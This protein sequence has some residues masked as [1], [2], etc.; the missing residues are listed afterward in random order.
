M[1]HP[2]PKSDDLLRF[3]SFDTPYWEIRRRETAF[4]RGDFLTAM[5]VLSLTLAT[6]EPNI[7][8]RIQTSSFGRF[9][10]QTSPIPAAR[11]QAQKPQAPAARGLSIDWKKTPKVGDTIAGYRVTSG[12]GQRKKPCPRCS[13]FHPAIDLGTPIGTPLYA[14][15]ETSVKC[16]RDA[17]G[18]GLVAEYALPGQKIVQLLHLKS[19]KNGKA[20]GG[21]QIAQSGNSGIGTGAHLDLRLKPRSIVPPTELIERTLRPNPTSHP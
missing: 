16:W 21:E 5:V 20:K 19:C 13:S 12:Y 17:N 3:T 2:L 14:V 15:T 18:G 1:T 4:K 10:A 8:A 9:F 11:Q 7:H 6:I